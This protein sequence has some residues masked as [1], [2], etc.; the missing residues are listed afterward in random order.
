M[1]KIH[2]YLLQFAI[3]IAACSGDSSLEAKCP[4]ANCN[5][6]KTHAEAQAAFDADEDCLKILDDDDDGIACEHLI[7]HGGSTGCPTTS[8]C[9]CSN[10]SK[11]VC[12]SACCKW[13][14]G[15]GCVCR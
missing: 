6:Y 8:N 4:E 9:G 14:V 7:D 13:V 12:E 3:A 1:K 5:N 15:T 10:K 11:S 2:L